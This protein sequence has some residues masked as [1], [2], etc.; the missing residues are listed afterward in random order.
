MSQRT[1]PPYRAEHVGSLLRPPEVVKA[2]ADCCRR[3]DHARAASRGRGHGD[4]RGGEDAGGAGAPIRHRRRD[5]P[6]LVAHGLLL[7]DRRPRQGRR[8]GAGA[9]QERG[10]RSRLRR[11]EREGHGQAEAGQDHLRRGFRVPQIHR[12]GDAQAHHPVALGDAPPRRPPARPQG[13]SR[14]R[15]AL[16][17]LRAVLA[18]PRRRLCRRGRSGSAPGLHLPPDRRHELGQPV[19]SAAACTDVSVGQRRREAPS[20]LYQLSSTTR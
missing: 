20:H 18:R 1:S 4:P 17:R 3:A 10:R 9:I 12:Q 5:A 7:P 13:L 15:E 14:H 8:D 6:A 11:R 2:R 19:R 16:S